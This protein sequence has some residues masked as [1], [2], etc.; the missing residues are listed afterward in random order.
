MSGTARSWPETVNSS[1]LIDISTSLL[2]SWVP[3]HHPVAEIWIAMDCILV[4]SRLDRCKGKQAPMQVV[5]FIQLPCQIPLGPSLYLKVGVFLFE[6]SISLS[7]APR[8]ART[9]L[10]TGA[11][12]SFGTKYP[13]SYCSILQSTERPKLHSLFI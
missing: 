9:S 5:S 1:K 4:D 11:Q 6:S 7:A 3:L 8:P 10:M 12:L 2:T 13:F